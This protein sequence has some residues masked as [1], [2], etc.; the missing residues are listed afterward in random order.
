VTILDVG[1]IAR[2]HGIKGE[3][4]VDLVT[5]RAERVEPG[6][7]LDTDRGPLTVVTSR[8]FKDGYLVRFEGYVTRNETETLRGLVLRAEA[9]SDG[10][11]LWVHELIG[12]TVVEV[13]GT[14]RGTVTAVEANP[15]SDL[16]VLDSGA[17]VPLN[18]VVSAGAGR[19]VVE[20]PAGL[21]E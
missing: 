15:A 9:L 17:L 8:P 4:V 7:V 13:D 5:D 6:S 18:F 21:F 14:E 2:A 16:L 11:E 20:V 3:V 12:S 19:I 10:D 1:R